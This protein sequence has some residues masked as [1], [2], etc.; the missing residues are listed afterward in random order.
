MLVLKE[1]W[2]LLKMDVAKF[3]IS[4]ASS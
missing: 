3:T 2:A 1:A 4:F